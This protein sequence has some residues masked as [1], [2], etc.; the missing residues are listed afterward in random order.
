MTRKPRSPA[1]WEV[2]DDLWVR[3]EPMLDADLPR[4]MTGR[5]PVDRRRV[6]DGILFQLRT[7]CPWNRLPRVYGDDSTLHRYFRRWVGNG[8]F[9]RVWS[10]LV[11]ACPDLGTLAW[12]SPAG[13]AN[14]GNGHGASVPH[15]ANGGTVGTATVVL[16]AGGP[17]PAGKGGSAW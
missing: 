16:Q 4:R 11:E 14:G 17:D 7:D 5:P 8:V 10:V 6:L 3:I 9:V 12:S 2:T 1:L 15:G 13:E